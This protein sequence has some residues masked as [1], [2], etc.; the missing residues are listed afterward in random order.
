MLINNDLANEGRAAPSGVTREAMP[1]TVKPQACWSGSATRQ[2]RA[3]GRGS[4]SGL[5]A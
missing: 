4:G 2:A 1:N 5:P 3:C